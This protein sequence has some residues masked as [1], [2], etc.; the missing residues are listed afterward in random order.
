MA[1]HEPSLVQAVDEYLRRN[2]AAMRGHG[3]TTADTRP[4]HARPGG[5]S[6]QHEEAAHE[7][8]GRVTRYSTRW[9]GPQANTDALQANRVFAVEPVPT[10]SISISPAMTWVIESPLAL[11]ST[12]AV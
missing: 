12:S 10:E 3:A 8:G 1:D 5:T 2:A 9:L 4:I 11:K 6:R 7:R